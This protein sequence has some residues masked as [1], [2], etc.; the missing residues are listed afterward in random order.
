MLRELG[1][2]LREQCEALKRI[3]PGH[4]RRT[5]GAH[6]SRRGVGFRRTGPHHRARAYV[7][8]DGH[9]AQDALK[10][11]SS[12]LHRGRQDG[13]PAILLLAKHLS[14]GDYSSPAGLQGSPC[15]IWGRLFACPRA[16]PRVHGGTGSGVASP[17]A[18]R[19]WCGRRARTSEASDDG[20]RRRSARKKPPGGGKKTA[21]GIRP[22]SGTSSPSGL[23]PKWGNPKEGR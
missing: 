4:G 8:G 17:P 5:K 18:S 3:G 20:E 10:T 23:P 19:T 2:L 16:L 14:L 6:G 13:L 11:P 21:G 15:H 1:R 22:R 9:Q 12:R 7:K